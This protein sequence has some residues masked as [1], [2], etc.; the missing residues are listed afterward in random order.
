M[1]L[2]S[3]QAAHL[4][5]VLETVADKR[6]L[7][8]A[9]TEANVDELAH[10][11][12]K[13]NCPLA[14][15]AEDLESTAALAEKVKSAGVEDIV[16]DLT[17]DSMLETLEA[18]TA[19]RR[20]ALKKKAPGL[21]Y[22]CM[23]LSRGD[24]P[25]QNVAECCSFVSKY[26]AVVLTTLSA[27]E[28]ILPVLTVRQNVYTDP[29]KPIQVE[30]KVYEIGS[31]TQESPLM[32]TTNFSLTYYTVEGE[33]EASRVPAH[34]AVIDTE[35]TSVLTAFASDKMTAENVTAFLNS[36]EVKSK[37][38]HR[39]VIIPGYVAVMSGAL[40]EES[41]WDVMVGPREASG[42]SK[43]LKTVWQAA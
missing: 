2:I 11:A 29:R 33:V 40:K 20:L 26:S 8:H 35:G 4:D 42:I 13:H 10:I 36:D 28:Q 16:L 7:I 41:G 6:P 14:V 32:I 12:K 22:P 39:K 9:A 1:V 17:C 43:Y 18:L 34:I 15:V 3:S 19:A 37:V 30:S 38:S 27:P 21:G 24:N 23:T 5:A 25:L 31:V